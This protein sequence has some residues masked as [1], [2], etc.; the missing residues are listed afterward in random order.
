MRV[1]APVAPSVFTLPG[2]LS[3]STGAAGWTTAEATARSSGTRFDD[4]RV[5]PILEVER[6]RVV[7][8][9]GPDPAGDIGILAD[10]P[11][12]HGD[13]VR[14]TLDNG[15]LVVDGV[16]RASGAAGEPVSLGDL[17]WLRHALPAPGPLNAWR[18]GREDDPVVVLDVAAAD[19]GHV[20]IELPGGL[21]PRSGDVLVL[22]DGTDHHL[23]PFV[24]PVP[25]PGTSS[26]PTIGVDISGD[27]TVRWRAARCWRVG[28]PDPLAISSPTSPVVVERI[29]LGIAVFEGE[30]LAHRIGGL[31]LDPRHP[32]FVGSLPDDDQLFAVVANLPTE[33]TPAPAA[34]G[35][36]DREVGLPPTWGAVSAPRFP[37]A[38]HGPTDRL[39]PIALGSVVDGS[40]A[41]PRRTSPAEPDPRD[42]DGLAAFEADLFVDDDLRDSSTTTLATTATQISQLTDP[43][44]RLRGIHAL[45]P[46]REVSMV[47]A[48][49]ASA[50]SWD[51]RSLPLPAPPP[52]PVLTVVESEAGAHHATWTTIASADEYELEQSD[53]PAF[54]E[55]TVLYRGEATEVELPAPPGCPDV[56]HL[57]VRARSNVAGAWSNTETVVRPAADFLSCA[58][59]D[60]PLQLFLAPAGS[61]QVELTWVPPVAGVRLESAAEPTFADPQP[62]DVAG[63][64]S[65]LSR[66]STDIWFRIRRLDPSDVPIGPWS[67]TVLDDAPDVPLAI[68]RPLVADIDGKLLDVHRAMLRLAAARGDLVALLSLPSAAREPEVT[69]HLTALTRTEPDRPNTPPV[70]VGGVP[71][72]DSTEAHSLSHGVLYHPWVATRPGGDGPLRVVPADGWAA[73]SIAR[74]TL[75]RG[76]WFAPANLPLTSVVGLADRPDRGGRERLTRAGANVIWHAPA[77]FLAAT[78]NTLSA[79]EAL[80]PIGARR[81]MILLRRLVLRAGDTYVFEPHNARFRAMVQNQWEAILLDLFARGAFAGSRPD[82]AFSLRADRAVN[83]PREVELGRFLVELA[84]APSRPLEF[85]RVRLLATGGGDLS[86]QEAA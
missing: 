71:P 67:N 64:S 19:G 52:P 80:R 54:G 47:A 21:I 56:R 74:R 34:S 22:D 30:R 17:I 77:G 75:D 9:T 59:P 24:D 85:I 11:L 86:V 28:D 63:M 84:V 51:V 58:A 76:A 79:G 5:L 38:G 69:A 49:D 50:P 33:G 13:T 82:E 68:N 27:T 61:D 60:D 57:R 70:A 15:E 55:A 1:G 37:L 7:E 35:V 25:A 73:G 3:A 46:I 36:L 83:P 6:L 62:T 26:L 10:R 32:S 48:P 41:H 4:Q 43:G 45:W 14:L 81:L 78:A 44:R 2:L 29:T 18:L 8:L 53:D 40:L 66:G 72:L 65:V 12:V 39:L 31:T 42:R 16:V 23:I 20:D